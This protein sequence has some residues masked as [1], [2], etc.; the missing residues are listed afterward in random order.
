M[1]LR[2]ALEQRGKARCDLHSRWM[3]L[4]ATVTRTQAQ[5]ETEY[6]VRIVQAR[7]K[8]ELTCTARLA[9]LLDVE[10]LLKMHGA[11]PEQSYWK[12]L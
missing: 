11:E 10:R 9:S 4:T 12:P 3:I 5:G 8:G 7:E 2:E 1:T 6:R